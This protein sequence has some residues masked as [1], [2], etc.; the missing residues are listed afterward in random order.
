MPNEIW[1]KAGFGGDGFSG[2]CE[3]MGKDIDKNTSTRYF[4]GLKISRLRGKKNAQYEAIEYFVE[5][6]QS[7]V[8]V[9][10]ILIAEW[11]TEKHWT[12]HGVG[13]KTSGQK[14]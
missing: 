3:R 11:K 7:Y 8:S 10:P 9:K 14:T 13:F 2:C 12:T 4:I 6:S 5:T 1:L